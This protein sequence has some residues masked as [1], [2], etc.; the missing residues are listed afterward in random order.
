[1]RLHYHCC[2]FAASAFARDSSPKLKSEA[3][4]QKKD[5]FGKREKKTM[6][7]FLFP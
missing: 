3:A 1:M 7:A 4:I 6:E 2:I 5:T